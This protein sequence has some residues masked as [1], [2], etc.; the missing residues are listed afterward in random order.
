[1]Q[2]HQLLVAFMD[3]ADDRCNFP[4]TLPSY[5]G[6][7]PSQSRSGVL[8]EGLGRE[9]WAYPKSNHCG[10]VIVIF[11]LGGGEETSQRSMEGE[12]SH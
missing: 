6:P 3:G 1:M 4:S 11:L 12:H 8:R 10:L 2:E 7:P 5:P 9:E